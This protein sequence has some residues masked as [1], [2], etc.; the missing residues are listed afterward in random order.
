[1]KVQ[2][3][4]TLFVSFMACIFAGSCMAVKS[5]TDVFQVQHPDYEV[6]PLTGVT[7]QHWVDAAEYILNGAF[8]YISTLDDPMK[9]PRQFE[10]T[11][12]NSE[13]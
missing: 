4:K 6:S 8:S 12:P 9:F 13:A 7:R 1:M 5:P 3:I 10:K 11:Y 2:F